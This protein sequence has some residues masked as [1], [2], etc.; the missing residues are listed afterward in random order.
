MPFTPVHP[1][2]VVPLARRPLV[3]PA[4][5]A[6]SMAPDVVYFIPFMHGRSFTHGF[7]GSAL[8]SVVTGLA[9]LWLYYVLLQEPLLA[10]LP[11]AIQRRVSLA[12]QQFAFGPPRRFVAI[13]VSLVVGGWTHIAWDSF[14]HSDG[15]AVERMA[16]LHTNYGVLDYSLPLYRLLQHGCTVAGLA[17]LAWWSW[18]WYARAGVRPM[19]ELPWSGRARYLLLVAMTG[20]ALLAGGLVGLHESRWLPGI[21]R[22]RVFVRLAAVNSMTVLAVEVLMLGVVWRLRSVARGQR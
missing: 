7:L 19:A 16:W 13:I 20:L 12:A 11:C 9:G 21:W 17:A 14:T 1:V 15:W 8:A 10:L 3:L 4:L 5:V 22:L 6:G 2:I 18:R